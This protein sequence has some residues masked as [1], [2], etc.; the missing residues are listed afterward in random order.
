[1]VDTKPQLSTNISAN[2][3]SGYLTNSLASS[4]AKIV[5]GRDGKIYV[6]VDGMRVEADK[7]DL[8][9]MNKTNQNA[10]LENIVEMYDKKMQERDEKISF[11]EKVQKSIREAIKSTREAF[12]AFLGRFG[13]RN[14]NELNGQDKEYALGLK[15]NLISFNFDLTSNKNSIFSLTMSNFMDTF[16]KG[17]ASNLIAFN[18]AMN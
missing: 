15:S 13:V 14:V 11:L 9:G 1:M 6:Y 8:F 2:T 5:E 12:W 7:N 18:N 17:K 4:R 3:K 10:W 16:H